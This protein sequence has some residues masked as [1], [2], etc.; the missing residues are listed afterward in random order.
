MFLG[1]DDTCKEYN[2]RV[3]E[4]LRDEIRQFN[5]TASFS[6]LDKVK[7]ISIFNL[8]TDFGRK[9]YRI[10]FWQEKKMQLLFGNFK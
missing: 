5:L 1:N 2:D 10:Y 8:V 4:I 6:L 7:I 9:G 3:F